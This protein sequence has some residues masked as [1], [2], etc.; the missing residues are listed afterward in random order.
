MRRIACVGLHAY[1]IA[2][3]EQINKVKAENGMS[4]RAVN[5]I[6]FRCKKAY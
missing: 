3:E 2:C 6:K 4:T 1:R 5:V